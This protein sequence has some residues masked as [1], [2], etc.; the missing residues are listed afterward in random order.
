MDLQ[1]TLSAATSGAV[2]RE[3]TVNPTPHHP[4]TCRG[5]LSFDDEG[6]LGCEH[7]T[8]PPH[9]LRTQEALNH[10]VAI[11]LIEIAVTL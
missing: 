5:D 2:F 11:L 10:S 4:I 8:V 9:D 3:D 1:A 6:R 7:V